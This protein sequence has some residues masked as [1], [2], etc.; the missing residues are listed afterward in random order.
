MWVK[1]NCINPTSPGSIKRRTV[2]IHIA[3]PLNDI[4]G[5]KSKITTHGQNVLFVQESLDELAALASLE[6]VKVVSGKGK[7]K[8]GVWTPFSNPPEIRKDADFL[9]VEYDSFFFYDAFST[10][11]G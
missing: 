8:N 10:D 7:Y 6:N 9:L 1:V 5:A 3:V 11:I 4:P 2:N